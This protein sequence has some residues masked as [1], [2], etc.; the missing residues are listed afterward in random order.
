MPYSYKD[1]HAYTVQQ[2]SRRNCSLFFAAVK[3]AAVTAATTT[4]K[5]QSLLSWGKV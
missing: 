1:M 3:L 4:A 2:P 5:E